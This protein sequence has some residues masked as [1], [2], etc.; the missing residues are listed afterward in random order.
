MKLNSWS[1]NQPFELESGSVLPKLKL[2]YHTAGELNEDKSNVVWV[3][4]ALT[5]NSNP[6]EWWPGLVGENDVINPK[7]HFIICVNVI[8][9]PYGSICPEDLKFPFFTVRDIANAQLLLAK[10]LEINKIKLAIGG[11][12]GGSQAL[13]FAF[14]FEGE[15]EKLVVLACSA[16]ETAWGIS[17]HHA[18]RL[19]LQSDQTF[20]EK[21][22][23]KKGLKAARA[24]GMLTYRTP[25]S[26]IDAQT[27][28]DDRIEGFSAASYIDYQGDK[29]VDRF[30]A[31][32]YYYLHK[33]LDA[34]NIGR[35]RG[36]VEFALSQVKINTLV[37]G[38][39]TDQ[40]LPTFLQKKIAENIP[41]ASYKEIKSMYGHDGF[42]IETQQ[43][44]TLIHEF[45]ND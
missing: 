38:I 37:I 20:G 27:D 40:L 42:L 34:H 16:K 41:N 18:Q 12:F 21:N 10:A 24:I 39:D 1:Y 9:S 15:I 19:A 17:I 4:H 14:T 2:V 35:N 32:S 28:N 30:T 44:T 36:G 11:S 31:L 6:M 26:F 13:E 43:L 22:G 33:C 45:I 5:A 29:L 25:N 8:G 7:E 3:F 23:G